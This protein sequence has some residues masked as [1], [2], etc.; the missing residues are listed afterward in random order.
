MKHCIVFHN[1]QKYNLIIL[2]LINKL[3]ELSKWVFHIKVM[4]LK[5]YDVVKVFQKVE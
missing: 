1:Q 4:S 3:F 2:I 5:S